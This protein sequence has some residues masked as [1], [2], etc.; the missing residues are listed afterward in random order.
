MSKLDSLS[1]DDII[2][3]FSEDVEEYDERE[4]SLP[5]EVET[6]HDA[7]GEV[8]FD[9]DQSEGTEGS[10]VLEQ[11]IPEK[12]DLQSIYDEIY[13][14]SEDGVTNENV[15]EFAEGVSKDISQDAD[16]IAESLKD[17]VEDTSEKFVEFSEDIAES[18]EDFA[19]PGSDRMT[20]E[21]M[22]GSDEEEEESEEEERTWEEHRD[23]GDFMRFLNDSYPSKIPRHSGD[24]IVGCEKAMLFL[25]KLNQQISEAIRN[26]SDDALE[27][28]E[29]ESVRVKI[30]RDM[31]ILKTR[32]NDLKKKLNESA[33]NE[34]SKKSN[35]DAD[36]KKEA[37]TQKVQMVVTPFERACAGIIING[38][39]SAGHDVE[40][41]Y[42]Y[43]KEKYAF[44]DRE[45][46]GIMQL[47]MDSGMPIFKDRGTIGNKPGE[48]DSGGNPKGF[49]IDFI[50]NYFA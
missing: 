30:M 12:L 10:V 17:L 38:T 33:R 37:A 48:K 20:K 29:V 16:E 27:T 4:L 15:V 5:I 3:E 41:V 7:D 25:G 43:L 49:G 23:V 18:D 35:Q 40:T 13:E 9:E 8:V 31:V 26:D 50:K 28:E 14:Y 45:E 44:T 22:F 19:F 21:V 46:L 2:S 32:I 34:F 39:V 11:D 6:I 47:L 24:S 36:I 1:F 42:E